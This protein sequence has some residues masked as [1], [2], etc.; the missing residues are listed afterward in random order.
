MNH[1]ISFTAGIVHP[2]PMPTPNNTQDDPAEKS[3]EE[4]G[5]NHTAEE[6]KSILHFVNLGRL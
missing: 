4:V 1:T 5:A 2:D 3:M 6:G